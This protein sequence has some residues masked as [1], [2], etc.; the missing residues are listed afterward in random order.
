MLCNAPGDRYLLIE[1]KRPKHPISRDDEAQAQEYADELRLKLPLKPIDVLVIGGG[2]KIKSDPRN[3]PPNLRVASYADI[4][5]RARH[6][7]EW[8]LKSATH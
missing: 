8:L 1:F 3:D 4:I 2:R 7:V 5:S 6:E